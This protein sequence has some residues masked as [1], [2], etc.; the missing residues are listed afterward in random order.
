MKKI[1]ALFCCFVFTQVY[2]DQG[3]NYYSGEEN[4]SV[5]NSS[6]FFFTDE[7]GRS[8]DGNGVVVE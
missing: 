7:N 6:W 1:I 2:S 5:F 8:Y 4:G 3:S